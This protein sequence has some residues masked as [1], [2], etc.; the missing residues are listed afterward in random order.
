MTEQFRIERNFGFILLLIVFLWSCA[1]PENNFPNKPVTKILYRFQDASV[2][3]QYHRSYAITVTGGKVRIVVDSYGDILADAAYA[4]SDRQMKELVESLKPHRIRQV[5]FEHEKSKCSGGT[6]RT[7]TVYS[8][9][10]ILIKGT[11]YTCGGGVEG[12]L[13]GDVD[14]FA[15]KIEEL[16][17]DFANLLKFK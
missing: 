2:P 14:G 15:K 11:A 6:S 8:D 16:I 3:P 12:N 1:M 7:I 5:N 17:P 10:V 4:V 13:S 9:D